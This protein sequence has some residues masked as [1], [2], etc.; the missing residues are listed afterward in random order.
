[1]REDK[2]EFLKEK[3]NDDLLRRKVLGKLS[4]GSFFKK[5]FLFSFKSIWFLLKEYFLFIRNYNLW[6]AEFQLFNL[7]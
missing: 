6:I 5:L 2:M 3:T 4:L 1:M 7:G